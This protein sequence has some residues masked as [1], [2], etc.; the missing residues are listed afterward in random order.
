LESPKIPS[1]LGIKSNLH[2]DKLC[3]LLND[4]DLNFK[5]NSNLVRGLDYYNQTVFEWKHD[6]LGAQN[7]IC[8]GG[9]YDNL[10][11]MIGG[12][13]TPAF[14]FA[15]GFERLIDLIQEHET[16][17]PFS[18]LDLYVVH[19]GEEAKK[20]S[21]VFA[22]EIRDKGLK[23]KVDITNSNIKTQMK[24]AGSSGA[25]FVAIFGDSELELGCVT[26]RPLDLNFNQNKLSQK[27]VPLE[28]VAEFLLDSVANMEKNIC[29]KT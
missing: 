3:E 28:T 12:K 8:G 1:F 29:E 18:D 25:S 6:S 9:R 17:T 15:I 4:F 22:E 21:V 5:I 11:E 19:L 10:V 14:G 23:V 2:K 26:I 16:L 24:R 13:P 27:S 20:K 7:T